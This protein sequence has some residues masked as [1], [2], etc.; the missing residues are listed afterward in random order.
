MEKQGLE[1]LGPCPPEV[2]ESYQKIK[3]R[4]GYESEIKLFKPTKPPTGGSPLIVLVYGGGF[5]I[6]SNDQLTAYG[7]QLSKLYGATCVNISYRLAPEHKFPTGINDSW[8]TVKWCAAN[9]ASF[10]ADPSKGFLLGGVS[11]GA[12]ITSVVAQKA[13]DEKLSPPLTGL[14][15]CVPLVFPSADQ[16]PEKYKEQWFSHEQNKDAPILNAEAISAI[17]IHLEPDAAS[18][19]YSPYN[20]KSPHK[21]LPR[22]YISVDGLDPLRDDGLIHDQ[23]LREHGVETRL[24]I[25]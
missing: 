22:T 13:L 6:G 1:A 2:E 25:W 24:D 18:D 19:L 9:A 21:G 4:D 14:W 17:G 3:M 15:L 8:D 7:R 12:N 5:V 10:G 11:A 16:V 20:T 23:V